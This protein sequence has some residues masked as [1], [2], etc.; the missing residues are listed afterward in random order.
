[1]LREIR[2]KELSGEWLSVSGADPL[3]LAGVL[4]P[5]PKLAALTANQR[6]QL[7]LT[8]GGVLAQP[9]FYEIGLVNLCRIVAASEGR[10]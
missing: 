4:T 3:N 8:C 1:M 2:R 10:R 7:A 5:G 9:G 6:A